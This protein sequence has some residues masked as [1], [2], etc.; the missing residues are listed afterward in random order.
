MILEP[1]E[2][3][4]S[5]LNQE[6]VQL[7]IFWKDVI[8]WT[9]LILKIQGFSLPTSER[10]QFHIR[11]K[12]R[13]FA[14]DSWWYY[15]WPGLIILQSGTVQKPWYSLVMLCLLQTYSFAALVLLWIRPDCVSP[16]ADHVT[17]SRTLS[18][19][20]HPNSSF[21]HFLPHS[22]NSYCNAS[23]LVRAGWVTPVTCYLLVPKRCVLRWTPGSRKIQLTQLQ[24]ETRKLSIDLTK[25]YLKW[26]IKLVNS[27]QSYL[28]AR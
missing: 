23:V 19:D 7:D 3:V 1:D 13:L 16:S 5:K 8:L 20:C 17:I 4:H 14:S 12:M 28:C 21:S 9:P 25:C 2:D 6:F 22:V 10:F 24:E 15:Y 27:T 11:N 26:L 18:W